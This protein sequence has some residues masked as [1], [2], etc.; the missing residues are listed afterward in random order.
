VRTAI[1][2]G[3]ASGIGR[4]C[5]LLFAERGCNVAAGDRDAAGLEETARLAGDAALRAV[6]L[7]VRDAEAVAA[8]VRTA[9]EAFGELHVLV[10]AAGIGGTPSP[11]DRLPEEDWDAVVDVSLRGTYLCCKAAIPELRR[12]GGGAIVTFGSVL[13]HEAL[14][15][16][17]AYGAA[18]AGIEGLTRAIAVDHAREG[19]RANCILPGS[20]D[21]PLMWAGVS[22]EE[23][24]RVRAIAA[25][26]VPLGRVADPVEIARVVWFLASDEASFV[27]GASIPADGG[28]LAKAS[29]TY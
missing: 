8:L 21:T 15:G 17:A 7:D 13:G 9:V 28:I 1:V 23:L 16:T 14:A 4:A 19:I 24:P 10:T 27:T 29:T 3:A 26:D 18:K 22:D 20:T 12:A 25:E 2:T 5:A 11:V 6:V